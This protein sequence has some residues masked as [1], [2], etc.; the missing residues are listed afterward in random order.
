MKFSSKEDIEAPIET[1]FAEISDF[2]AF[3]RSAIRRG[4]EV[5]RRND[6]TPPATGMSWDTTFRLRGKPR[7]M[8]L[9]LSR[10]DAPTDVQLTA[11]GKSF[12]GTLDV[13][14]I[15]LS[16]HRTRLSISVEIRPRTLAGRLFVQSLK[17]AKKD[18]NR[19]FKL[20]VADFAQGIE[21]RCAKLA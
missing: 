12:E 19:R 18:M 14:L 7:E 10:F 9:V 17:L 4:A 20:K 8:K 13:A 6:L 15:A 16:P 3:E 11:T 1:V 2:E 21:D 5:R